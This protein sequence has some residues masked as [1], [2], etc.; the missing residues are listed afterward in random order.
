MHSYLKTGE[1]EHAVGLWL[2]HNG[3]MRFQ[4]LFAVGSAPTAVRL[5]NYLNGGDGDRCWDLL[6][7]LDTRPEADH[8]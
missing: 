4:K 8:E 5:V 6:A 1:G 7:K 2:P 3:S